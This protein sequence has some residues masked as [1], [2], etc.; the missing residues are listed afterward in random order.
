MSVELSDEARRLL[1]QA[2][3]ARLATVDAAGRPHLV[4]IVFALK[5]SRLFVPID[6]KPKKNRDPNAL[7]RV[8]NLR[9]NPRASILVDHYEEDW[10]RLAWVR[11][12]GSVELVSDGPAYSEGI[13]ALTD[14]YPQYTEDPLPP[15]PDG[16]LIVLEMETI[17]TWRA[18]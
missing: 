18:G 11:V 9:E 3:V 13:R 8:R 17:R 2:R 4:P 10:R 5:A 7:R 16:L 6:H 14:R 15:A 12:D 1:E